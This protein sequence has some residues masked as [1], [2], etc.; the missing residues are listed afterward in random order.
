[1]NGRSAGCDDVFRADQTSGTALHT[2]NLIHFRC[3]RIISRWPIRR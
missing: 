1:V 2:A 3:G